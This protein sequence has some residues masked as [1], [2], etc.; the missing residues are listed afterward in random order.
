MFEQKYS[1]AHGGQ[2]GLEP[3]L[4]RLGEPNIFTGD[5][6]IHGVGFQ[7]APVDTCDGPDERQF[8]GRND[9]HGCHDSDHL[10]PNLYY[11]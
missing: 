3:R 2:D 6:H 8:P 7:V 10:K 5:I 1:D 4:E 11:L 9:R